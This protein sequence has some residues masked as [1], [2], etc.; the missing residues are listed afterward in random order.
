MS[1]AEGAYR[2]AFHDTPVREFH[3]VFGHPVN[4]D[5]K[6]EPSIEQR[7]LRVQMIASELVELAR[8]MGVMLWIRS[9]L[10]DDEDKCVSVEP[11]ARRYDPI[12]AADA[13]G[14]IRY[15][16]D[17]GNLICG[18]PGELVL[19]EIHRSN[20]SKL[21]AD[22]KPVTRA[23]GKTIKGPN[24]FKPNIAKVIGLEAPA[25]VGVPA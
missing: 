5:P 2:Q 3:E 15:L 9:E 24:Y 11:V 6:H 16:V 7:L 23:D 4:F 19:A 25:A 13:F 17:G 12:E 10:N 8:A 20:M 22:G 1:Y 21:G 18:F 14:D